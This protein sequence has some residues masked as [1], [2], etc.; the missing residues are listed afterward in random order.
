MKIPKTYSVAVTGASGSIYARCLCRVL[1][2][3]KDARVHLLMSEAG[4]RVVREELGQNVDI[5]DGRSVMRGLIGSEPPNFRYE[6]LDN[7][8]AGIASG[9]YVVDAMVVIPCS[10]GT[11]GR[12]AAGTGSNLIERAA[13]VQ[14]KERRN[15]ILVARETPLSLIGIENMARVARAGACVLPAMPGFYHL[16]KSVDDLVDFVVGKVLLQMGEAQSL[17]KRRMAREEQAD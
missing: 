17:F 5:A 14:L 10:M 2:K 15:L 3:R 16:P 11:L 1:S 8:G 7:I 9:S 13:D 6:A 4:A 12:I